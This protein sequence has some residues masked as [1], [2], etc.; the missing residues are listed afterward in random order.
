MANMKPLQ[1]L[2]NS[3]LSIAYLRCVCV[4]VCVC[5]CAEP[6]GWGWLKPSGYDLVRNSNY[7]VM[8][9]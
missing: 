5:V 2:S 3:W 7:L 4:C 6:L 8:V 1:L 9:L